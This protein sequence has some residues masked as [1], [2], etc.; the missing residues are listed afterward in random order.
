LVS[1]KGKRVSVGCGLAK[2]KKLIIVIELEKLTRKEKVGGK[3]HAKFA[4]G[5]EGLE[6]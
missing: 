2:K 5:E 6:P 3:G 1:E 4:S